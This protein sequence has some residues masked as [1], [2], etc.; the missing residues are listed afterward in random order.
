PLLWVPR[1]QTPA[2]SAAP[3]SFIHARSASRFAA[4]LSAHTRG[5]PIPGSLWPDAREASHLR[6]WPDLPEDR[7]TGRLRARRPQD[8]GGSWRKDLDFGSG[9]R[10]GPPGEAR[11][12][13]FSAF[14]LSALTKSAP[15]P[16]NVCE[17]GPHGSANRIGQLVLIMSRLGRPTRGQPF[18]GQQPGEKTSANLNQRAVLLKASVASRERNDMLP[19]RS[20]EP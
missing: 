14:L 10:N 5:G 9:R 18:V 7:W 4:A 6:H 1:R 16:W 12:L 2:A 15:S 17:R 3:W 11:L 8:L 13:V 19:D 20:A